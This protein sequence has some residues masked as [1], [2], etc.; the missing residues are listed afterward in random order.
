MVSSSKPTCP[1]Q[2]SQD[3]TLQILDGL[4]QKVGEGE[5]DDRGRGSLLVVDEIDQ[6]TCL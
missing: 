5:G 1:Y 2:P 3:E 6:W 4:W